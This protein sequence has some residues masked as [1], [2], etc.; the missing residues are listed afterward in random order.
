MLLFHDCLSRCTLL[1]YSDMSRHTMQH[2][3]LPVSVFVQKVLPYEPFVLLFQAIHRLVLQES[4]TGKGV[5]IWDLSCIELL[6]FSSLTLLVRQQE[7]TQPVK[8]WVVWVGVVVCL[9]RDA[10]LHTVQLMPLSLTI[11][12]F[13]KIQIGFTFLVPAHPG[14]PGKRAV[15]R[16]CVCYWVVKC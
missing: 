5:I 9:K 8:N 15:K 1:F 11:S 16:V 2:T 4:T 6:A 3:S 10:D 7:G 13:S 12:C 14:S